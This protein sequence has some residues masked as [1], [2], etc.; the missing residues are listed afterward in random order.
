[1]KATGFKRIGKLLG[2]K[3]LMIAICIVLVCS[4]VAV[5][6][7]DKIAEEDTM[8]YGNDGMGHYY[9]S[10]SSNEELKE[11]TK[12]KNIEI[13]GEGTILLKNGGGENGDE[14]KL[15]YTDMKNISVFGINS[16]AF[17]YG[18]TGSGSGLAG[19]RR[20]YLFVF[21]SGRSEHQSQAQGAVSEVF[22]R[23]AQ[24]EREMDRPHLRG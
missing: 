14:D 4:S 16:D 21:R 12:A 2:A 5:F 23:F 13:A 7:M 18:G 10:F 20:G 6:A 11:A 15:P 17:G 19:G 3:L 8:G 1:M 24:R 22:G 9:S